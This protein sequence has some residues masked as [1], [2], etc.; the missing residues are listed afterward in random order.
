MASDGANMS[1]VDCHT[2]AKHQMKGK[3]Y[4]LSSMNRNR[5]QCEEC[6][7]AEPHA[8]EILNEHTLKV[9]CQ[10]CHIPDL[11]EGEPHEDAVGLV[12]GR[13]PSRR[14]AVRGEGRARRRRLHVD[15]GLLRVGPEREA[16]VPVVRRHRV[17]LPARRPGRGG[18]GAAQPAPRPLRR[19]GL[20]DRPR[21]GPP[22]P[23]AV[24]RAGPH[25]GAAQARR[26]EARR[27]RLLE[28]LRHGPRRARGHGDRRPALQRQAGLRRDGDDVARQPHGGPE[29]AGGRLRRV[30][31]AGGLAPRRLSPTS[32]CRGATRTGGSTGWDGW[33]SCCR[34]PAW[35][36][37]PGRGW[38]SR[39]ASP[40][41]GRTDEA[42]VRLQGI[43]AVLALDAGRAHPVPGPHRLRDPRLARV[44]RVRAGR[45]LPQRGRLGSPR[46]DRLRGLL[47]PHDRRVAAV[48][49]DAREPARAGRVLRGRHLPLRGAPDPQERRSAS[50]TRCRGS[51]T[52][53]SRCW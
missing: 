40:T 13:P 44:L 19:P 38:W 42:R 43:R 1:C 16:R 53:P 34:S 8:K 52:S 23:P 4:S 26:R 33:R 14:P 12:D 37:T 48:R 18:P 49:A 46:P 41:E 3:S 22:R 27:G 5:V 24:G 35:C 25:H 45:G 11:R 15:Q 51:S 10:A 21:E 17:P 29:G 9:S 47:A 7:G 39:G 36:C 50:S 30:P 20:E 28:G 31:H 6:H 32:T 2:A